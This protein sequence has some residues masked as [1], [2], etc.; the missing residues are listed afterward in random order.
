MAKFVKVLPDEVIKDF[1]M[2][3]T[4][5]DKIFGQMTRAGAKVVMENVK[6]SVPLP[7]MA[8]HVKLT[9]TYKTPSDGGI[10]TKVYFSGYLPFKGNRKTF[11]RRGRSGG[12][13]YTTTEGVPVDFLAQIYE[14]G[15][16][17]PSFPKKPF[18]R[19]SFKEG[20]IEKAMLE[21]QKKASGGLLDE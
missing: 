5:T 20:Q 19:S 8:S 1:E 2:I 12:A 16:S 11:K 7:E 21:A 13:V 17:Y 9:K 4:N 14:Y 15:R 6:A 3:Y 18:F 10:N